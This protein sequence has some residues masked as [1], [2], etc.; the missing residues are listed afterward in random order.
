MEHTHIRATSF[1]L[2]EKW[3]EEPLSYPK[4]YVEHSFRTADP[5]TP[6]V[7]I[8]RACNHSITKYWQ[9]RAGVG[10]WLFQT[11]DA[12]LIYVAQKF[13]VGKYAG[14]TI[15]RMNSNEFY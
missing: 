14:R 6:T 8:V 3:E 15:E 11:E 10:R 5:L 4:F 13:G 12:A 9:V 2:V 1:P 7:Q